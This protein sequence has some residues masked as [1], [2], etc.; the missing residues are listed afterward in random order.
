MCDLG[1]I[2]IVV[3]YD[4]DIMCEVD[5]LIDV[6]F[7]VG[8]FGGE[9]VAVGMFKQVVCNSKFIIGQYL[10][11]KRVILVLEECCVGNG[12]FIEVMGVCENNL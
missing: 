11:G 6:G 9:I 12:C 7:G 5:Y 2:F 8:V 10:L 1:N 3:E 4:E